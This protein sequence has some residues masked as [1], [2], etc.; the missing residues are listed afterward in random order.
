LE[1]IV[2]EGNH[3]TQIGLPNELPERPRGTREQVRVAFPYRGKGLTMKDK[4]VFITHSQS[5]QVTPTLEARNP[6]LAANINGKAMNTETK[7]EE[8]SNLANVQRKGL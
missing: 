2:N 1:G 7:A 4:M 6:L 3:C 5:T 8:S